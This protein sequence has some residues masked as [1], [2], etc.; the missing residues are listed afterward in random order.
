MNNSKEQHKK[1]KSNQKARKELDVEYKCKECCI[2]F[3]DRKSYQKHM[4]DEHEGLTGRENDYKFL[5]LTVF[6]FN[7]WYLLS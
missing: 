2:A 4:S 7:S 3:K 6:D 1:I 5:I